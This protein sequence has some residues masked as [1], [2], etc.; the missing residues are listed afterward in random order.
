MIIFINS[1]KYKE[2]TTTTTTTDP[3]IKS[4]LPDI[5][6]PKGLLGAILNTFVSIRCL[7]RMKLYK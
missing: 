1:D 7:S 3:L 5:Q 4:T 6:H 2:I